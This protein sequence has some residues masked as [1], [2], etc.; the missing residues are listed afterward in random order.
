MRY[1]R[2]FQVC[3]LSRTKKNPCGRAL[4]E[5]GLDP[6]EIEFEPRWVYRAPWADAVPHGT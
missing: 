1:A 2:E 4:R 6:M 3:G 5:V